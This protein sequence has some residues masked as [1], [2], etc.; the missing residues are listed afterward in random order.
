ME[1]GLM[2][3]KK[4]ERSIVILGIVLLAIS[5]CSKKGDVS[6][7]KATVAIVDGVRTVQN[8][9]VPRYRD[10]AFDLVEDLV[11]GDE[12]EDNY[13]FPRG[14]M[15]SI[16][17]DG[18]LFVCDYGNR[19]VQVYDKGGVFIRTLGRLGQGPGEYN[20]PSSVHLDDAGNTYIGDSS[21]MVVFSREGVFQRNI[22]LKMSLSPLMLG[23]GGTIVGTNQPNAFGEGR[24]QNE[25]IQ[26][27]P[28]GERLRVLAQYPAYGVSKGMILRHWYRGGIS[29]CRRSEDSLF[30]GFSLAYEIH[31]VDDEGRTLLVFSKEEEPRSITSE[32]KDVT[33]KEG[34]P[35]WSGMGDPKTADLGMPDHRPF[36][37]KFFSDDKGRLYVVRHPSILE[38]NNPDRKVDVFSKDGLYLY[39]MTWDFPAQV[40]KNGF[41]YEARYDE[42]IGLTRIIRH[43][44]KNWGDFKAE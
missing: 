7:W 13:F 42:D 25:I 12:N 2:S 32:E 10:F 31:V 28:D 39:R 24:P 21:K 30:F 40:V 4:A 33:R 5:G 34:I 17:D 9:D 27:G 26:L 20:Y 43:R 19:R 14:L 38:R 1:G 41:F 29:F 22:P 18:T 15:I 36:F 3:G 8:P 37:S 44:I 35:S 23:P 11:I 16:A 6:A